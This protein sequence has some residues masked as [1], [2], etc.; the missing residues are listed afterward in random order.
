MQAPGL[1]FQENEMD[2]SHLDA[3]DKGGGRMR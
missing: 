3:G 2:A 1:R